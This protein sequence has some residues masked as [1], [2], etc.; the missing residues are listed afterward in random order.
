MVAHGNVCG[1]RDSEIGMKSTICLV[2]ASAS[3][4]VPYALLSDT[5][6]QFVPTFTVRPPLLLCGK[7]NRSNKKMAIYLA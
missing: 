3:P 7:L 4:G 5:I 6:Y 1:E 2:S